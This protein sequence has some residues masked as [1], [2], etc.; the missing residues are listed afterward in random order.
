M[1]FT[2]LRSEDFQSSTWKRL[3]QHMTARLQELREQNDS[4]ATP[5]HT[6]E[7]RG[8]IAEVK[9]FLALVELTSAGQPLV[10][11]EGGSSDFGGDD[12]F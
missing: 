4:R 9:K 1:D 6:S 7:I 8:R 5:E 11:V 12:D 3:V 10:P 2:P